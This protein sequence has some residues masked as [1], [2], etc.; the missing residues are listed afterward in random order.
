MLITHAIAE[1]G[2]RLE[3]KY[4][5]S[6]TLAANAL[7]LRRGGMERRRIAMQLLG[8]WTT[9]N[10]M[11]AKNRKVTALI[12]EEAA[13]IGEPHLAEELLGRGNNIKTYRQSYAEAFYTTLRGR[14]RTFEMEASNAEQALVLASAKNAVEEAYY[15]RYPDLRPKASLGTSADTH[16][17][18]EKCAKA[19][20]GY[21][22][23]HGWLRPRK[24]RDTPYSSSGARAG[25]NAARS[26][27]LG[28]AV[29]NTAIN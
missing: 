7:R 12:K 2:K 28:K 5:P 13:R 27:D 11:T 14:I 1:F 17:D 23:E 22:R 29:R 16:K 15:A 25:A 10:E 3:P 19:K 6:E 20:S 21:C 4:D 8:T 9:E 18:C 24:Y 26:V